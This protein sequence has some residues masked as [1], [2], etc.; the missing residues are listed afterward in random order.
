LWWTNWDHKNHIY[1]F[2]RWWPQWP[3]QL[4]LGSTSWSF[5]H[6]NTNTLRA[7]FPAHV[8]WQCAPLSLKCCFQLTWVYVSPFLHLIFTAQFHLRP[9]FRNWVF[10]GTHLSHPL[11]LSACGKYPLNTAITQRSSNTSC[12]PLNMSLSVLSGHLHLK[13]F[14]LWNERL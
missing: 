4:P 9:C 7:K 14:Q 12:V 6:L 5:H 3:N 8:P 11:P 2:W 13:A 1:S 10:I